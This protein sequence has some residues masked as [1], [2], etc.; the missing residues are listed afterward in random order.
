MQ[1]KYFSYSFCSPFPRPLPEQTLHNTVSACLHV[2]VFK[3]RVR[4]RQGEKG[5]GG[6]C[7]PIF[8]HLCVLQTATET[9]THGSPTECLCGW[10]TGKLAGL[11]FFREVK[12]KKHT[13][14]SGV[15]FRCRR[16]RRDPKSLLSVLLQ[17]PPTSRVL[18][19]LKVTFFFLLRPTY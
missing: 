5:G 16:V 8:V 13:R 15:D 10:N 17:H 14:D 19:A 7:L 9:Q 6:E 11:V 4:E 1:H 12:K 18:K 3:K 2:H